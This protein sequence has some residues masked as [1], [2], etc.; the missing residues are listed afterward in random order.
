MPD[1]NIFSTVEGDARIQLPYWYL[2]HMPRR[3]ISRGIQSPQNRQFMKLRLA[4]FALA[5]LVIGVADQGLAGPVLMKGAPSDRLGIG[6]RIVGGEAEFYDRATGQRFVPRGNN[7]I[8]LARQRKPDGTFLR[9]HSTFNAGTYDRSAIQAALRQMSDDGYNVVR[10]FLNHCCEGGIG[11]ANGLSGSYMDNV[12]DFLREARQISVY[13]MFTIDWIPIPEVRRSDRAMWCSDFQCTTAHI[14]S[15]EGVWA[16]QEFFARFVQ[17]LKRRNA[18]LDI[19][20]AYELRNELTFA[21]SHPPLSLTSGF[22]TTANRRSYDLS[23]RS[24]KIKMLEEGLVYW[25]NSVR[26][27]ILG[28]DPMAL[29]TVG[30]VPPK[31][32]DLVWTGKARSSIVGAVLERSHLDFFD[33][34]VYP[35]GSDFL[36]EQLLDDCGLTSLHSK[37]VL[38]GEFGALMAAFP[39]HVAAARR[40]PEIVSA[41][42][43]YGIDG[44]IFWAWMSE[45]DADTFNALDSGGMIND[46]LAP[47]HWP[48]PCVSDSAPVTDE[49]LAWQSVI[50]ASRSYEQFGPFYAADA[51]MTP[52]N[53]GAEPPQWIEFELAG[54]ENI[55]EIRLV[56]SQT[57]AGET[58][59][60]IWVRGE[61]NDY[62]LFTELKGWTRDRQVLT[63]PLGDVSDIRFV[64]VL[65]VESPSWVG[66]REIEII[67]RED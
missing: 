18:P 66:W 59:H 1:Q 37:P 20:F 40:M 55:Q 24:E 64:K 36:L 45:P 17:E 10:V 52:W 12:A 22:L 11:G 43:T 31:D 41:S 23:K 3:G 30:F 21:T 65:T 4:A 38:F 26:T 5:S 39:S 57:P 28:V 54:E 34:H 29:V 13:V 61:A 58:R 7:Y 32:P 6:T 19:V 9:Y 35:E 16:N 50:S 46:I 25:I 27:S 47:V 33:I 60:Q 14:L 44:W 51:Y 42:C 62:R 53:A 56:V 49:N 48:D 67:R 15:E 8:R 63:V 2:A